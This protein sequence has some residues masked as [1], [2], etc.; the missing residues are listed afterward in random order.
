M[1]ER[2]S[3]QV[4]SYGYTFADIKAIINFPE[5]LG[6]EKPETFGEIST[7]SYSI[8]REK[9]PVRAIGYTRAKGYTKGS[10]TVA[11]TLAFTMLDKAVINKFIQILYKEDKWKSLSL[12]PD[13]LPPFDI[14]LVFVNELGQ[15]TSLKLIGVEIA[16]GNSVM[17]INSMAVSEQYSF[18]A[19]DII[20]TDI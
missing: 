9:Y 18:V 5:F 14:D 4:D 12:L 7:L 11:G 10:R 17:S 6:I 16:E 8:Y 3:S 1:T 2:F 20:Q 15:T 19:Q 13:E